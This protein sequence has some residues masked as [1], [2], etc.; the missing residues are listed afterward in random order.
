MIIFAVA[1]MVINL[2]SF[3]YYGIDKRKAIKN[4][5]RISEK[6]LLI[7]S[8]IGPLGALLG[9]YVFRHK[10]QKLIFKILVPF[11]LVLHVVILLFVFNP[12]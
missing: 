8:L 7:I 6:T 9:M 10:T 4:R 2:L 5:W 1:E 11:F 3:F 12:F